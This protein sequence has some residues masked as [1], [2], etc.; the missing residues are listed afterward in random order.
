MFFVCFLEKISSVAGKSIRTFFADAASS[1]GGSLPGADTH[2]LVEVEAGWADIV[3]GLA[4]DAVYE[5]VA[6]AGILIFNTN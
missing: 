1:A 5:L 6:L 2:G 4:I 3:F